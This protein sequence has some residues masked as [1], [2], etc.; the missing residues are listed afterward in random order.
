MPITRDELL[1]LWFREVPGGLQQRT[2]TQIFQSLPPSAQTALLGMLKDDL[3]TL[4]TQ[5]QAM[6]TAQKALV[7]TERAD[8]EAVV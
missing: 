6:A 3:R 5:R 2:L 1:G 4:L 7:D 8:I